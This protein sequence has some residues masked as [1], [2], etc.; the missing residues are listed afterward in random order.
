M[1]RKERGS[2]CQKTTTWMEY[3][4]LRQWVG[5][6]FSSVLGVV[7]YSCFVADLCLYLF[8]ERHSWAIKEVELAIAFSLLSFSN[9]LLLLTFSLPLF[10]W[11]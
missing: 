3:R 10:A 8:K 5:A 1:L 4:V 7:V 11:T 9:I 2:L 6:G